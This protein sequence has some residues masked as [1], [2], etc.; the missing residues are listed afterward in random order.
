[1]FTNQN[2]DY[3]SAT[4]TTR[5]LSSSVALV[6]VEGELDF[7]NA[8]ELIDTATGVADDESGVVIDLSGVEFFGSAGF[9]AL[10]VLHERYSARST[11]WAVVPSRNVDRVV[12][13][14]DTDAVVPLRT[15]LAGALESASDRR[16]AA[17][18]S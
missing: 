5:R 16:T 15:S 9:S 18:S 17:H 4:F 7:T 1:M 11:P 6:S 14:C 12:R 8:A 3:Q 13:I 10:H 2:T